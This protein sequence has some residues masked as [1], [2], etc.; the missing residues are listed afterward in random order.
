MSNF[1]CLKCKQ[2]IGNFIPIVDSVCGC[3]SKD[4]FEI[5]DIDIFSMKNRKLYFLV[6]DTG[7]GKNHIITNL[8][9]Y[10]M[11]V[12]SV[13]T[14]K[15]RQ[16]ETPG[17]DYVFITGEEFLQKD[18][19]KKLCKSVNYGSGLYGVDEQILLGRMFN[20]PI[21][22]VLVVEPNGLMQM[23]IWIKANHEY[24]KLLNLDIEIIF[25]KIPRSVR[26][27]NL[28]KDAEI[29]PSFISSLVR[30]TL[31]EKELELVS[32]FEKLL[33]RL[34]RNGDKIS[35]IMEA[36]LKENT[37]ISGIKKLDI[38]IMVTRL[39]SLNEVNKFIENKN[40]SLSHLSGIIDILNSI[41]PDDEELLNIIS[42]KVNDKLNELNS[43]KGYDK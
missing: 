6:G 39:E 15:P 2:V 11:N 37:I 42:S 23:L 16:G 43:G 33:D 19:D 18:R 9:K 26:F 35:E 14:R 21:S 27:I 5:F 40:L 38:N 24:F 25:L 28:L 12:P 22:P 36:F 7:S 41:N 30:D 31:N 34:V 3:G 8:S 1:I 20:A 29:P 17:V 13:T 10:L 4:I 32:K